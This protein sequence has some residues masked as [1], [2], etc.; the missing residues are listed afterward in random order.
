MKRRFGVVQ[1][2][3]NAIL[4]GPETVESTE[5][6]GVQFLGGSR[7]SEERTSEDSV[8]V[9]KDGGGVNKF[10]QRGIFC[11]FP[12]DFLAAVQHHCLHRF[13]EVITI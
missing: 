5:T 7:Q 11:G 12:V 10:A 9:E 13:V 3:L 4:R 6:C 1:R 2:I 8:A